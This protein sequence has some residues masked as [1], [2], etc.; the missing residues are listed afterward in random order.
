MT[1]LLKK[2]NISDFG[3]Y[4]DYQWCN[5][6][7]NEDDFFKKHNIIYGGNYSGKTTLSRIIY[8]LESK[9]THK[10]YKDEAQYNLHFHNGDIINESN[11]E[12][13]EKNQVINRRMAV[14]NSDFI[15]ENLRWLLSEEGELKPF[16]ILGKENVDINK[17]L[18]PIETRL[19]RE[20][21]TLPRVESAY[22][23]KNN[24]HRQLNN[25]ISERLTNYAS[26]IRRNSY[27]YGMETYD[28]SH[29]LQEFSM[30]EFKKIRSF[31]DEETRKY[32]KQI[33]EEVKDEINYKVHRIEN[34]EDKILIQKINELLTRTISMNKVV[35]EW[36]TN[37]EL[38]EWIRKAYE[39]HKN[40]FE[41]CQFCGGEIE[42][43]I[44]QKIDNHFSKES[45]LL[46]NG[47]N[48]QL[49]ILK[50]LKEKLDNIKIDSEMFSSAHKSKVEKIKSE[51]KNYTQDCN[52]KIDFIIEEL[53]FRK[54]NLFSSRKKI[55]FNLNLSINLINE[56]LKKIIEKHNSNQQNDNER[57]KVIKEKLRN[58]QIFIV[59]QSF[60]EN[61]DSVVKTYRAATEELKEA[62]ESK[63]VSRKFLGDKKER[64]RTLESNI[65][66]LNTKLKQEQATADQINV[67]LNYFFRDE[68]IEMRY[69]SDAESFHVYRN[70]E[71]AKNLS[72]GE[73]RIIS[74]CYFLTSIHD[75]L[76][77]ESSKDKL[78]I[79][80]DDP[81]S[82]L[83]I[84]HIFAVFSIIDSLIVR[85]GNYKQL[86]IATHNLDFL[87][88][89]KRLYVLE[90]EVNFYHIEKL[91][92]EK[93]L[94]Y[95]SNLTKMPSYLKE[96]TTEFHYLF[97]EM[98]RFYKNV[99]N[100]PVQQLNGRINNDY[101]LF[102]NIPN[103]TRRFLEV[104]LFYK[105]PSKNNLYSKIL[106]FTGSDTKAIFV[107]RIINEY[108][109][110][111]ALE[112]ATKPIELSEL[113]ECLTIIMKRL[114]IKDKEQ[115]EEL[116]TSAKN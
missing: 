35:E 30:F 65:E 106:D 34:I 82:S 62:N 77:E 63:E 80:I 17:A 33:R 107:N 3:S 45:E 108:S 20:K 28:R 109:H 37:S 7:N 6:L 47:I 31:T 51:L 112:R 85:D 104:Y 42:E 76:K 97:R 27:Y 70:N 39:I 21:I 105:Y 46:E 115:Y 56:D 19:H 40:S 23:E 99:K 5:T 44:Y 90:E 88:Y 116:K 101:T 69:I 100:K 96:Y 55:E 58:N 72:E 91:R 79:Y 25:Q 66:E 29:L 50:H 10:D 12:D 24:L 71:L 68:T 84:N 13:I 36:T 59:H 98:Y 73:S 26:D 74:F 41:E 78:I 1:F 16:A 75:E 14:Y 110:T 2:L 83:D 89:L 111:T 86:F 93:D 94:T 4:K 43:S 53:M 64:I 52:E 87:K 81:I 8:S 38:S 32:E 54:K 61:D 95:K 102:Y 60:I 15:N 48:Q 49:S 113:E 103:I 11:L 9:E 57:K 67:F 92:R 22:R 18:V 114:E